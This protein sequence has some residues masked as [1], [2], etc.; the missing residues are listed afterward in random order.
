[1]VA[2]TGYFI[3]ARTGR[4]RRHRQRLRSDHRQDHPTTLSANENDLS[5]DA[6]LY[7]KASIGDKVW[8]DCNN[9]GLQDAGEAGVPGITVKLLDASGNVVA[10]TLTDING[11]HLSGT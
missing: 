4:Q 11:N 7:Q 10:T 2:P 6:G 9:N 5:W 1:M 3:S 8:A